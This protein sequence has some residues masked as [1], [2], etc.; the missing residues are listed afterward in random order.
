MVSQ[1]QFS[2]QIV[3]GN[4]K[5]NTPVDVS[6]NIGLK[7]T[8]VTQNHRTFSS[9]KCRG[10]SANFPVIPG[11]ISLIILH[12]ITPFLSAVYRSPV[13]FWPVIF[14]SHAV[15]S[16][17]SSFEYLEFR[18]NRIVSWQFVEKQSRPTYPFLN[19]FI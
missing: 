12:K 7:V 10:F 11:F 18:Y 6:T 4:S 15:T 8:I 9:K 16:S 5:P 2:D 17:I 19:L 13:T 14:E 1:I 3:T